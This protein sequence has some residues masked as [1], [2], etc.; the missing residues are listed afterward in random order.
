[1]A[2]GT[3]NLAV[4]IWLVQSGTF[5]F[6]QM[7]EYV[8]IGSTGRGSC[9]TVTELAILGKLETQGK[10]YSRMLLLKFEIGV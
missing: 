8:T 9:I 4:K 10:G 1:M 5:T 7:K 2:S 6:V 3:L